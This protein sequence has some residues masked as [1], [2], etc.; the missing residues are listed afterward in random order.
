MKEKRRYFLINVADAE[1][2]PKKQLKIPLT[3]MDKAH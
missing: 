1:G 3:R 2:M